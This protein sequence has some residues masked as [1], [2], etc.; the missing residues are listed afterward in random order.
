MNEKLKKKGYSL[1]GVSEAFAHEGRFGHGPAHLNIRCEVT[2]KERKKKKKRKKK[3]Q[4]KK[5][6]KRRKR[7]K[8]KG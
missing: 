5:K 1:L 4:K 3:K 2:E 7:R 8:K 6:K